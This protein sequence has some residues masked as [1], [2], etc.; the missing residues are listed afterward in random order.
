MRRSILTALALASLTAGGAVLAQGSGY[1]AA[2]PPEQRAQPNPNNVTPYGPRP[3][4]PEYRGNSGW[5]PEQAYGDRPYPQGYRGPYPSAVVPALPVPREVQRQRERERLAAERR[6]RERETIAAQRRE[7]EREANENR[8]ARDNDFV[9]DRDGD[10]IRNRR[11]RYPD[12]PNR[13]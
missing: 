1:D 8:R 5:T 12:D 7:R 4:T 9:R 11:D 6:E 3:G 2:N 10:G 13:W